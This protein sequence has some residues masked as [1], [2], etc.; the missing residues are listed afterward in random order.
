MAACSGTEPVDPLQEA[1]TYFGL[2]EGQRCYETSDGQQE[3]WDTTLFTQTDTYWQFQTIS[4]TGGFTIQNRS[5]SLRVTDSGLALVAMNDCS[6]TCRHQRKYRGSRP[7]YARERNETAVVTTEQSG[8]MTNTHDEVHVFFVGEIKEISMLEGSEEG[9][10]IQWIR[11]R[12]D[13]IS[14]QTLSFVPNKG[15][16]SWVDNN[17]ETLT[18]VECRE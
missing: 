11:T 15:V 9:F 3:T 14:T 8:A 13:D 18:L 16:V 7:I 2:E 6:N 5:L 17:G 12:G 1:A 10:D 4:R